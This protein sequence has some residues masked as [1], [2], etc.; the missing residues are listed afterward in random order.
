MPPPNGADA[1]AREV[2]EIGEALAVVR[3]LLVVLQHHSVFLKCFKLVIAFGIQPVGT[4]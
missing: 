4:V 1:E 2:A 3:L